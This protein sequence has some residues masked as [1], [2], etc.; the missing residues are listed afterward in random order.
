MLPGI[1]GLVILQVAV[2]FIFISAYDQVG[3]DV[4]EISTTAGA[5]SK[6]WQGFREKT[7]GHKLLLP[8]SVS[9][10]IKFALFSWQ[11]SP[12]VV[13]LLMRKDERKGSPRIESAMIIAS[14]AIATAWWGFYSLA[15][16]RWWNHVT[17]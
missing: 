3:G 10:M 13:V 12:P 2:S 9:W 4:L 11:F 15:V 16:L 17:N 5:I 14:T 8:D 6:S 7:F 1:T